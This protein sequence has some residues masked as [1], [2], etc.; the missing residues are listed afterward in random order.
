MFYK[1]TQNLHKVFTLFIVTICC[2]LELE[3]KTKIKINL[4]V[5]VTVNV[6]I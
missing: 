1:V 6:M 4:T 2:R 5:T 3:L